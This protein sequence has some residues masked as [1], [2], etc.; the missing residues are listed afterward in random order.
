LWRR[1]FLT[2]EG[3]DKERQL[4]QLLLKHYGLGGNQIQI[5][6][7]AGNFVARV[8]WEPPGD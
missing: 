4:R 3:S 6:G 7:N 8:T 1:T 5:T 2:A